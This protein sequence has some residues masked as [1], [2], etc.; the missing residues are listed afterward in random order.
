LRRKLTTLAVFLLAVAV[1]VTVM[2]LSF[3]WPQNWLGEPTTIQELVGIYVA[4]DEHM[5]QCLNLQGDGTYTQ[6]ITVKSNSDI[7]RSGGKWIVDR[8]GEYVTLLEGFM[9]T[10]VFPGDRPPE[11]NPH[12]AEPAKGV[13]ALP[14]E[15]WFGRLY[16]GSPKGTQWKKVD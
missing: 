6:T 12:Y 16:L 3:G 15:Y 13:V 11:F 5:R 9:I 10:K 2:L 8:G 4:D 1:I 14:A 7:A